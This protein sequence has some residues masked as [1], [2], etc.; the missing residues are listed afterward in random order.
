MD[1]ED[2][3]GLTNFSFGY[4]QRMCVASHL[5]TRAVYVALLQLIANFM[6]LKGDDQGSELGD[7]D[8]YDHVIDPVKG[9]N[10]P[11][12]LTARPRLVPLRFVPRDPRKLEVRLGQA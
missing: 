5:A 8:Q 11:S 10:D 1:D 2:A 12:A 7:D 6:I 9:V 3:Q 4:G